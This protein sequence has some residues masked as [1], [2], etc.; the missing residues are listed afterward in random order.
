ML[1]AAPGGRPRYRTYRALRHRLEKKKAASG[2]GRRP[3]AASAMTAAVQL[4]RR[5][6]RRPTGVWARDPTFDRFGPKAGGEPRN[7]P[8]RKLRRG[9]GYGLRGAPR[10]MRARG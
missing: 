4:K 9:V 7:R 8:G 6:R 3:L 1:A 5:G 2:S 10:A